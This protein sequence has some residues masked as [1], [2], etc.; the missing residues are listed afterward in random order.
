MTLLNQ[1]PLVLIP[2]LNEQ[3]TI[4]EVVSSVIAHGF[5]VVVVDD[6]SGDKTAELARLAGAKILSLRINLG[7]GE[8]YAAAF[9]LPLTM[10]ISP[11]CSVMLM[12]NIQSLISKN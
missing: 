5:D 6:G 10:A 4:F 3:A 9:G 1:K 7:V 8:H 2:A 11:W 12:G